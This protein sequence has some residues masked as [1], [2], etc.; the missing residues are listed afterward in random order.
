VLAYLRRG[1]N[2][3]VLVVLNMSGSVQQV[4]FDLTQQGFSQAK[5]KTLLTTL[6]TP[7]KGRLGKVSLEPFSVYIARLSK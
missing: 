3:A 6:S 4:S 2:E 1:Q 7:P 5:V